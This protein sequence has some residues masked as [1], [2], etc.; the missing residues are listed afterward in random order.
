MLRIADWAD[1]QKPILHKVFDVA[2]D[3]EDTTY[4]K[5]IKVEESGDA[6]ETDLQMQS[7]D[8]IAESTEGGMY[9]RVEVENIRKQTYTHSVFKGEIKI[10]TEMVEDGKYRLIYDG[11]KHLARAASRTV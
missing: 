4:D 2:W 7:P 6:Y 1:A 3:N 9:T 8:E 10:T 5:C 11:V